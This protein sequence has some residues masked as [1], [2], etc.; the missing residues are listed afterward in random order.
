[1]IIIIKHINKQQQLKELYINWD[2]LEAYRRLNG[3]SFD[4]GTGLIKWDDPKS[5][6]IYWKMEQQDV[7]NY[8]DYL[9]NNY[10]NKNKINKTSQNIRKRLN[11]YNRKQIDKIKLKKLSKISWWNCYFNEE[12][13]KYVRCYLSGRKGYAK[14][15]SKRIVRHRN[16]FSLKGNGYR[17]VYDYWNCIF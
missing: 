13:N 14:W 5:E 6:N 3:Q 4:F 1:M 11:K 17:K 12:E 15:C 10:Q 7:E 2:E 9:E 8:I 16:D